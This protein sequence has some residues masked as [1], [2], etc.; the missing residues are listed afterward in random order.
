[1]PN[2]LW[3]YDPVVLPDP[4]E[5]FVPSYLHVGLVHS[6]AGVSPFSA[7]K[8]FPPNNPLPDSIGVSLSHV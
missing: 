5:Q 6:F 8:A 2:E 4:G 3:I 1:M 7:V